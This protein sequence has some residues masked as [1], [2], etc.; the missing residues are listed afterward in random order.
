M[1]RAEAY[2]YVQMANQRRDQERRAR[3]TYRLPISSMTTFGLEKIP[4]SLGFLVLTDEGAVLSS[5]G[6][7]ENDEDTA[8]KITQMVHTATRIPITADKKD[9]L[10]RMSII[11]DDIV[12]MVTMSQHKILI[13]KRQY[14][15]PEPVNA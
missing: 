2:C 5:G 7:L 11:M 14:N 9:V 6:E 3:E 10:K 13:C 12:Y 8:T 1:D 15:P 4:D